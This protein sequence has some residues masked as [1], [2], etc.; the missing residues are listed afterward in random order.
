MNK[1][2]SKVVAASLFS[3]VTITVASAYND[4]LTPN[5]PVWTGGSDANVSIPATGGELLG[6]DINLTVKLNANAGSDTHFTLNFINGSIA[7]NGSYLLCNGTS[8]AGTYIAQEAASGDRMTAVVMEFKPKDGNASLI[9]EGETLNFVSGN[10]CTKSTVRIIPDSGKCVTVK[11]NH[12]ENTS[13]TVFIPDINSKESKKVLEYKAELKISCK[14]PVCGVSDD[15]LFFI[16]K[17]AIAS[18]NKR[19]ASFQ[20]F[21]RNTSLEYD[22]FTD[23]CGETDNSSKCE[24]LITITNSTDLNISKFSLTPTFDGTFPTGMTFTYENN[25]TS[26]LAMSS[27]TKLDIDSAIAPDENK[28]IKL[29]FATDGKAIIPTG[30]LTAVVTDFENNATDATTKANFKKAVLS[31]KEGLAQFAKALGSKFTVTYMNPNYK[32]FAMISATAADTTLKATVTDTK[33]VTAN[34]EFATIKKGETVFVF[35][36]NKSSHGEYDLV[37]KVKDS[38]VTLNNGWRVDFEVTSAVDVAAYMEQNG[39]Q[40]TLTVLYPEY[41]TDLNNNTPQ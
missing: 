29:T 38:G 34:I 7:N 20:S 36:D 28:T 13:G 40:R 6:A 12:G 33:G 11:S 3:A 24:T 14:V 30:L 26:E 22:C 18:V 8:Q 25:S 10:D 2:L 16:P 21:D 4:T 15:S 23:G 27:G 37:Q 41:T 17:G 9:A 39:G 1:F 5:A 32:S 19:E 31:P 35:A